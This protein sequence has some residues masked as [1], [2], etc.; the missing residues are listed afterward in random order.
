MLTLAVE[1]GANVLPVFADTQHEHPA[2]YEYLDVLD[3]YLDRHGNLPIVRVSGQDAI[4]EKMALRRERLELVAGGADVP[5]YEKW[6]PEA[7]KRAADLMRPTGNLFLDVSLLHGRFPSPMHRF[8]TRE[9][10]MFPMQEHVILPLMESDFHIVWSWQGQRHDES[11]KRAQLSAFDVLLNSHGKHVKKSSPPY[12]MIYRPILAWTVE[13]VIAQHKKHG[14]KLNPLY[15]MGQTR[16]GCWPCIHA[17]KSE[18]A[19]LAARWPERIEH[20]RRMERIISEADKYGQQRALLPGASS[21]LS[22]R[23]IDSA[24]QWAKSGSGHDSSDGCKN[25]WGLCESNDL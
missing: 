3:E 21:K 11:S 1:R 5:R 15:G 4:H 9:L 16:V 13:D 25:E 14:L 12:Q 18:I 17:R 22:N 8:C 20:I 10:K 2:V 19:E 7:A 6:T 24:V 23:G